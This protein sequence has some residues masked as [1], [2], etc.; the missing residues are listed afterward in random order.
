ME[1]VEDINLID[2]ESQIP[3]YNK[4]CCFKSCIKTSVCICL[5]ILFWTFVTLLSLGACAGVI[6]GFYKLVE[7]DRNTSFHVYNSDLVKCIV[8]NENINDANMF[9]NITRDCL[10]N[11]TIKPRKYLKNK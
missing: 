6:Y 4:K 3:I 9:I 5:V 1:T 8:T 11:L 10:F 2:E 7:Y